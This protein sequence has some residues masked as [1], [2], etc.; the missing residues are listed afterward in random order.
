M[1][2]IIMNT[3][4]MELNLNE[5]EMVNGGFRLNDG[6]LITMD[7]VKYYADIFRTA[8]LTSDAMFIMA[9]ELGFPHVRTSAEYAAAMEDG[10]HHIDY[11]VRC[12]DIELNR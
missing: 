10:G 9:E 1:K 7:V 6:T 12:W 2:K 3:N 8:K 4:A 5:M 11:W